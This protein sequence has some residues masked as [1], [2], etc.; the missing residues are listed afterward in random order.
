MKK[1]LTA[2]EMKQYDSETIKSGTP[3]A[4]LMR[5]A[6]E[7]VVD[8]LWQHFPT[9]HVLFCCGGGNNGGD[10]LLAASLFAAGGGKASVYL[11]ANEAEMSRDCLR[12]YKALPKGVNVQGSLDFTGVT[13]VVDAL[14]GIGLSRPLA[15]AALDT[16]GAINNAGLPVLAVD[17]PTGVHAD[18][19]ALMGDAVRATATVTMAY[20]KYGH[21]LYPGTAVTGKLTVADIGV[22]APKPKGA[23][24]EADD[25][26]LLPPRPAR[27]HKGSFGRVLI[28]GGSC[29]MAG[30]AHLAAKAAYRAGAGLVEIFAPA[31]N[32]IIHQTLLPEALL[33]CYK[34]ENAVELLEKRLA[35]ADAVAIGMGLSTDE[36]ARALTATALAHCKVPL[37][38][39]ADALNLIAGDKALRTLLYFRE[40]PTVLTPHPAEA[41][42]LAALPVSKVLADQVGTAAALAKECGATVAL[43][44][45][46]TVITDGEAVFLNEK[47]NSG[48]ATGGSGDVLAGIVGAFLAAKQPPLQA[49]AL[50]VLAHAMAGD[51]ATQKCGSHG[52]M[53]SD[54]IEGLTAVLP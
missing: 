30:A 40:E 29:A 51:A 47:G 37:V 23:L 22:D 26:S 13:A 1:I 15:G 9:G 43:K 38:A 27:A 31:E 5:R 53:A 8:H 19:G 4:T 45:A 11:I 12:E 46:R 2:S 48:M 10:G 42:R 32:R 50:G 3:S 36:T 16:V 41:A 14:F 18:T 20:P 21:I 39:D 33:T 49:A 44:D 7:A 54:I 35:G 52:T 25:L 24:L 17:I 34:A 28:V 6:A